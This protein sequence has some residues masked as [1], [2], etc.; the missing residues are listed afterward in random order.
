[1]T[2]YTFDDGHEKILRKVLCSHGHWDCDKKLPRPVGRASGV[3]NES[4]LYFI[5]FVKKPK[6]D[7]ARLHRFVAKFETREERG[8]REWKAINDLRKKRFLPENVILPI[9][10]NVKGEGVIVFPAAQG[11]GNLAS[12]KTFK[13]LLVNQLADNP[14]NCLNALEKV[15][16]S[17]SKAFHKSDPGGLGT[18]TTKGRHS[19]SRYFGVLSKRSTRKAIFLVLKKSNHAKKTVKFWNG[20]H[21]ERREDLWGHLCNMDELQ[22]RLDGDVVDVY[23]S[24]IHGD[25][26][27]TNALLSLSQDQTVH[28]DFII[29]VPHCRPKQVTALDFARLE[30]DFFLSVLHRLVKKR[31]DLLS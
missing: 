29:D 11:L 8:N 19:W 31:D 6:D 1:M 28:H 16:G 27:L 30:I 12:I 24:R 13:D 14:Q 10:G 21:E 4:V 9:A 2:K 22:S 23:L 25:L 3:A 7:R 20:V 17:L 5:S 26:N 18:S 15:L